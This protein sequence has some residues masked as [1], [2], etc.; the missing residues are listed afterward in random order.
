MRL[1]INDIR[2]RSFNAEHLAGVVYI[3][4]NNFLT[5]LEIILD[6]NDRI[7]DLS[8]AYFSYSEIQLFNEDGEVLRFR[9]ELLEGLL[10]VSSVFKCE[11]YGDTVYPVRDID[12]LTAS[13]KK[14]KP[15]LLYDSYCIHLKHLLGK[16]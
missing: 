6:L 5:F 3:S 15:S 7:V 14:S 4:E 12:A 2:N 9:F 13:F 1:T 16:D 8:A 11:T 10:H